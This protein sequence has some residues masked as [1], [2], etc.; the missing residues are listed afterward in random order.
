MAGPLG[1]GVSGAPKKGTV[2]PSPRYIVSVIIPEQI[3]AA[4]ALLNWNQS[5]LAQACGLPLTSVTNIER[6]VTDPKASNLAAI[7]HALE[8]AGVQ[9][10]ESNGGGPGVRLRTE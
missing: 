6:G 10:I 8:S 7:Q 5:D 9:F 4:R 2:T 1:D 3:R